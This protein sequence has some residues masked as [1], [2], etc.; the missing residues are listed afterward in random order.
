M[1]TA[2]DGHFTLAQ[3]VGEAALQTVVIDNGIIVESAVNA[4]PN[5]AREHAVRRGSRTSGLSGALDGDDG[6]MGPPAIDDGTGRGVPMAAGDI[7]GDVGAQNKF[8]GFSY[9]KMKHVKRI[10]V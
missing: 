7:M 4:T 2:A 9:L 1:L 8:P 6:L 3:R 10:S 5:Y